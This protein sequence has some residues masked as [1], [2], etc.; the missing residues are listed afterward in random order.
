MAIDTKSSF[1]SAY[2]FFLGNPPNYTELLDKCA[3]FASVT[4]TP[5]QNALNNARGAWYAWIIAIDAMKYA[6]H[7][8]NANYL[9]KLPNAEQFDA[10]SLYVRDILDLI[11]DFRDKLSQIGN[12]N[13]ITSNPD[14]VIISR[15]KF[16]D[17]KEI[18]SS[19][20]IT[21]LNFV[22]EFYRNFINKCSLDDV[23]GH[24]GAKTSVRPDRRIQLLHE[25]SLTK[26][27]YAHLQT[28]KWLTQAKGVKYYAVSL[29]WGQADIRGLRSVATHSIASASL[30]PQPAVDDVVE[31]KDSTTANLFFGRI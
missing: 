1:I 15:D 19:I 17:P 11:E 30:K 9:I 13:L 10:H 18:G 2:N 31:M 8:S 26:A 14:F 16:K 4:E 21:D 28:R 29:A 7:N 12:V 27:I 23:I 22:D 20:S 5:T 3:H 25:G 6:Y 24:V